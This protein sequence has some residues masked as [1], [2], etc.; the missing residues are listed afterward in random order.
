MTAADPKKQKK[1]K[2]QKDKKKTKK[3]KDERRNSF[4]LL[5]L[6]LLLP[7]WSSLLITRLSCRLECLSYLYNL[8]GVVLF[9]PCASIPSS[10]FS[11][12][13]LPNDDDNL[14]TSS[15][16]LFSFFLRLILTAVNV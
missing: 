14:S 1:K 4:F 9:A 16:S 11:F 2:G 7:A 12:S 15:Q 10:S 8:W 5:L 13:F 3:K 6:L